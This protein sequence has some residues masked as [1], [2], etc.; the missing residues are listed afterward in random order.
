MSENAE[1][2]AHCRNLAQKLRAMLAEKLGERSIYS[3]TR[4]TRP[5]VHLFGIVY[6]DELDGL[7]VFSHYEWMDNVPELKEAAIVALYDFLNGDDHYHDD[8][9]DILLDSLEG[10]EL[11]TRKLKLEFENH[12]AEKE[13]KILRIVP[14][15]W[16]ERVNGMTTRYRWMH[17]SNKEQRRWRG[18]APP[19]RWKG[20]E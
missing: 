4:G 3:K 10:R 17:S 20:M 9:R 6:A 15:I 16:K 14:W 1:V 8:V 7:D 5:I 13:E 2:E 18:T 11:A 12:R 19:T